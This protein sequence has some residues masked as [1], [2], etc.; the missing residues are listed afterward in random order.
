MNNHEIK[1]DCLDK[2]DAAKTVAIEHLC[3]QIENLVVTMRWFMGLFATSLLG[4]FMWYVQNIGA[5]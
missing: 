4:F 3:K 2:S 5:K 1:I